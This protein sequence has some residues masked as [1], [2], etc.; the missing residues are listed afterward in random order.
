V[1]KPRCTFGKCPEP[2]LARGWCNKHWKRW[3]KWGDPAGPPPPPPVPDL[4]GERWLPIPGWEDLYE[5]SSCGRVRGMDR[6]IY[7]KD[8]RVRFYRGVIL[9]GATH[10]T[11]GYPLVNLSRDHKPK[12]FAVHQLVALA[13]IGPRP[14]GQEVRHWDG[15]P[16]NN[17]VSNLL[18]GTPVENAQ[19]KLR[20]GTGPRKEFCKRG[21]DLSVTRFF[22]AS[23]S[24]DCRLCNIERKREKREEYERN[25]QPPRRP[26][27]VGKTH[28]KRGHEFTEENT[29]IRFDG[30]RE[31]RT[32]T[33][34]RGE[35]RRR[36]KRQAA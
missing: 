11:G 32:C 22:R 16:L 33:R 34:E 27:N 5:V 20:H 12:G 2:Q 15:N 25:P 9:K 1:A 3:R 36:V 26:Q 4:P 18:Y 8:G 7:Y 31:C 28:C 30:S 24:S 21:H 10:R 35:E 17:N 29:Y 19:D 6:T 23:G 14:E 13:F